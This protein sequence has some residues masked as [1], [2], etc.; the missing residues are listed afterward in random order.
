MIKATS[1]L[2]NETSQNKNKL[3]NGL[4]INLFRSRCDRPLVHPS[5]VHLNAGGPLI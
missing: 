4:V 5:T 1:E 2:K 3:L